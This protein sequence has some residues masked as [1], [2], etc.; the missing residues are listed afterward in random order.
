MQGCCDEEN[1]EIYTHLGFEM[2]VPA[3]DQRNSEH[4][5]CRPTGQLKESEQAGQ[6]H[7]RRARGLEL[8]T[9]SQ[10]PA[11]YRLKRKNPIAV[12]E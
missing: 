11:A 1:G 4:Q 3:I 6:Q 8:T 12:G 10:K 9:A 5:A 7:D 2:P